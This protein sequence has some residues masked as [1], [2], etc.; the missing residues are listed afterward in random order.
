MAHGSLQNMH[1][2]KNIQ[3]ECNIIDNNA[4]LSSL[5]WIVKYRIFSWSH[6]LVLLS[7][8]IDQ[9]STT[10]CVI[11]CYYFCDPPS[12]YYELLA[13]TTRTFEIHYR[14][15]LFNRSG[16]CFKCIFIGQCPH[17][18]RG[19]HRVYR[20]R[21]WKGSSKKVEDSPKGRSNMGRKAS[22][23]DVTVGVGR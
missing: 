22:N 17:L 21:K 14:I 23:T 8:L 19:L 7:S 12:S 11:Q 4:Y 18:G 13:A 10:F 5:L 6:Q 15:L 3:I 16:C 20:R 1:S 9:C 2:I